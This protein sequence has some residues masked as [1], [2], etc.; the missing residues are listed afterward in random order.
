MR[1]A[2][3]A[4]VAA[5]M[6]AGCEMVVGAALV[7]GPTVAG[8]GAGALS[9]EPLGPATAK[10]ARASTEADD[11]AECRVVYAG[12]PRTPEEVRAEQRE[13]LARKR[14]AKSGLRKFQTGPVMGPDLPLSRIS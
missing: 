6:L 5:S 1:N 3:L 10:T 12:Y 4:V 8:I 9:T 13:C 2:I 11:E 7:G 14:E